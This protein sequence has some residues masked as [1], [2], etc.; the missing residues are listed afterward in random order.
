MPTR[1]PWKLFSLVPKLGLGT[2]VKKLCF[3]SAYGLEAE[4][5]DGHSQAELGN[6]VAK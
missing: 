3:A 6:E 1:I 2:Q 4:L 5:L